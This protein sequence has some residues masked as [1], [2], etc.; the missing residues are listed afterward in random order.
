MADFLFLK[1]FVS[2]WYICRVYDKARKMVK[3]KKQSLR[4]QNVT[5]ALSIEYSCLFSS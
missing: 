2:N 5:V 3:D 4:S 1:I